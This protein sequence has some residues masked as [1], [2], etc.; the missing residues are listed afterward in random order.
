MINKRI[1]E[2]KYT[3]KKIGGANPDDEYDLNKNIYVI[4]NLFSYLLLY[5]S[6]ILFCIAT[7]IFL[8]YSINLTL[9][10]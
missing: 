2:N 9:K 1:N 3:R 10:R 8:V 4:Y 7:I 5:I 6:Y